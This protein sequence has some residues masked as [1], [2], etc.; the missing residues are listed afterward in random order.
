MGKGK[1]EKF[2]EIEGFANVVQP[3]VTAYSQTDH[4]LKGHWH[5]KMFGNN[6]P[7]V[8]ELG[9]GKGEYTVGLARRFPNKNFIGVD[10]K[11]AR[12]WRGAKTS[13]EEQMKNVAFLRTRIETIT[14]YFA[15][16]EIS[17]I[18]VTFPDPQL[19]KR[20]EKKRLTSN[21]FLSLYQKLLV[22]NGLVNLKT[23]SQFL[24]LY[25]VATAECNGLEIDHKTA[26]LYSEPWL[27]DVLSI[28]TYYEQL[29][30]DAGTKISYLSFH[31]PKNQPLI[32]PDGFDDEH[33]DLKD[34][35]R[36]VA[37]EE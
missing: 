22:D 29:H 36:E 14:S 19:K 12:I 10:I 11:G 30:I 33:Q 37:E 25:T 8:L 7:I 20:R 15:E 18:W 2:Q 28:K 23:D 17:E 27:D 9:C 32:A 4:E 13:N 5:E 21:V 26:D 31:L 3:L 34:E 6:N 35:S 16:N 24:Y 1:L